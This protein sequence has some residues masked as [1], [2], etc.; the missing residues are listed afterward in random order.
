MEYV[1]HLEMLT[2]IQKNIDRCRRLANS[3][4][5]DA[6]I[7]HKLRRMADEAEAIA[8]EVDAR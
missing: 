6:K 2:E 4:K 5:F 3:G 7:S 8:R 1:E